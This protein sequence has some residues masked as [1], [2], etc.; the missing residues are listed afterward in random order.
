MT[1]PDGILLRL[2]QGTEGR[3]ELRL[4]Y[5]LDGRSRAVTLRQWWRDDAGRWWPTRHGLNLRR[6]DLE[7]LGAA[8]LAESRVR[9]RAKRTIEPEGQPVELPGAGGDA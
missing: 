9:I 1:R 6:C 8:L 2:P 4:T 3:Y 5:R 7:A